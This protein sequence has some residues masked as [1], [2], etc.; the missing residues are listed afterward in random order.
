M[1][2]IVGINSLIGARV[3]QVLAGRGSPCM[4]TSRRPESLGPGVSHL[5][6]VAPGDWRPPADTRAVLLCS[7]QANVQRCSQDPVGTRAVNVE[8]L[9]EVARRCRDV[10]ADVFF[11]SSNQVFDGEQSQTPPLAPLSPKTEYGRQKA[12][13]ER[14]VLGWKHC[15]VLRLTKIL[16]H[17]GG[18]LWTWRGELLRGN[19]V[20]AFSDMVMAPVALGRAAGIIATVL[21]KRRYGISQ[22][23]AS[24]DISYAEAARL[25]A[26]QVDAAEDMVKSVSY[27]TCLDYAPRHTSLETNLEDCGFTAPPPQDSILESLSALG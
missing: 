27:T 6:L 24:R 22:I 4:G 15:G 26:R 5:D 1:Y 18:L 25:L 10:G 2:L 23:S 17:Q 20:R 11:L 13:V 3:A 21:E 14:V 9:L 19:P 7:A 8:G 12:D 16:P